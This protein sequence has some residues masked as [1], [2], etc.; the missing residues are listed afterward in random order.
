VTYDQDVFINVGGGVR[1]S[2][3]GAD[4]AGVLAVLS[5]LR[6]ATLPRD[7]VVFGEVGLAGEIRPVPNGVERLREAAKHG[8]KH[9]IIPKANAPK[10]PLP[11]IEVTPV[12]RLIDALHSV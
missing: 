9:A 12:L 5:S 11:D 10:E 1:I 7:L 6:N 3:T 8:F 2:E 4:L